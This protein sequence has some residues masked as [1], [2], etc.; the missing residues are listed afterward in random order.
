MPITI[1][2][3]QPGM[4]QLPRTVGGRDAAPGEWSAWAEE[5]GHDL[6]A[7]EGNRIVGG[8]HVSLVGRTEA[9]LE[10]L[11]VRPDA[12][13]RGIAG[14]LVKEGEHTA[15]RYGAAVARTAI[16]A[17]EYAA[18][19]V[20]ERAGYRRTVVCV[21]LE[22]PLPAGPLHMPYDAP[23]RVPA[24]K[25]TAGVTRFFEQIPAVHAWEHLVPLGWRFRRVTI[26]MVKGLI[27]D[28][29]VAAA[30]RP[31][32]EQA[33]EAEAY[34]A[35]AMFAARDDAAVVSVIDGAPPGMQA[36]YA[37]VAEQA[38]ERGATR[39]VVFAPDGVALGPLGV[40]EWTPHPW[41]PE[42]LQI[43]EKRLAS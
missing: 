36:V 41:C 30:L 23:L 1:R 16:P 8:I 9:W 11:R 28:R 15:R 13:G 42:G 35:A 5:P 3:A 10:N 33:K 38:R 27:K 40:R 34:Q 12:Q 24:P 4:P 2:P 7:L 22:S 6:V 20:A 14:S 17:H 32:P 21:V 19:G 26:E 29:R 18:M 25:D 31:G 43:V 39:M 37:A